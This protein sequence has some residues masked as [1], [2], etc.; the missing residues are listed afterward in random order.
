MNSWD[1]L[2][3]AENTYE[4]ELNTGEITT[5]AIFQG[6]SHPSGK[7]W[8]V[9]KVN[10]MDRLRNPSYIARIDLIETFDEEEEVAEE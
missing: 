1:E 8:L 7:T 2:L 10:G 6:V 9:F 3:E 4:V 5:C